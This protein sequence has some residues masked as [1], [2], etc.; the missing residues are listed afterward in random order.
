MKRTTKK[1]REEK[2]GEKAIHKRRMLMWINWLTTILCIT[3]GISFLLVRQ[4]ALAIFQTMLGIA[5]LIV[6]LGCLMR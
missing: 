5:N 3:A 6:I 2:H 4:Y 1:L